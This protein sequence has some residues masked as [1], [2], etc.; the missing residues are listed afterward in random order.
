ML[1]YSKCEQNAL[2]AVRAESSEDMIGNGGNLIRTQIFRNSRGC[3]CTMKLDCFPLPGRIALHME[4]VASRYVPTVYLPDK[5][6]PIEGNVM[7]RHVKL[8]LC[9]A[10]SLG[11]QAMHADHRRNAG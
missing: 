5:P 4:A 2:P 3:L 9:V 7:R 10:C 6:Q 1:S 11:A 8:I